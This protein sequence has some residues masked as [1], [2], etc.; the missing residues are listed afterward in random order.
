MN[1][2]SY[3]YSLL[4]K[5]LLYINLLNNLYMYVLTNLIFVHLK[6][7]RNLISF[8]VVKNSTGSFLS[9]TLINF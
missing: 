1:I 2:M 3:S 9:L 6:T 4:H 8:E 5:F 7:N